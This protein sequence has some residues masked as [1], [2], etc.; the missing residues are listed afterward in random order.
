MIIVVLNNRHCHM[1]LY[2]AHRVWLRQPSIRSNI[3]SCIKI[4]S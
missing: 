2:Y 4:S 1:R 3:Q